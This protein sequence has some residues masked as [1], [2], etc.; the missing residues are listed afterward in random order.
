[1]HCGVSLAALLG[2]LAR[3]LM[4]TWQVRGRSGGVVWW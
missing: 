1:M 4:V 2:G 3:H